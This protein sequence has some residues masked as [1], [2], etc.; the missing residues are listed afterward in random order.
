MT[1]ATLPTTWCITYSGVSPMQD[2]PT[3]IGRYAVRAVTAEQAR[4]IADLLLLRDVGAERR[5]AVSIV[6]VTRARM[7]RHPIRRRS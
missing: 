5:R 3:P 6:T 2:R 7:R 1:T 4:A